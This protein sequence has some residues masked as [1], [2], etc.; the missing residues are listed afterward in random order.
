MPDPAAEL[1]AAVDRLVFDDETLLV[2]RALELESPALGS[3]NRAVVELGGRPIPAREPWLTQA[4]AETAAVKKKRRGGAAGRAER[5]AASGD[6][7]VLL[8]GLEP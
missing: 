3:I 2:L 6:P 4:R 7:E 8:E 1:N 5:F